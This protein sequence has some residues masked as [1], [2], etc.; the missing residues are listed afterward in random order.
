M[1]PRVI[2]ADDHA[3]VLDGLERLIEEDFEVAA[4]VTNGAALVDA[5]RADPPDAV[6]TDVT[7]PEVSGIQAVRQLNE[8]GIDTHFIV[9][10]MHDDPRLAREALSAGARGFLLKSA[11]GRELV[12]AIHEVLDGRTYLS[13]LI[14]EG[15]LDLLLTSDDESSAASR[16]SAARQ[17]ALTPRQREVLQL[18]AEGHSMKGIARE[19]EISRRTVESHKYEIMRKI[20]ASSTAELVLSAVRLGLVPVSGAAERMA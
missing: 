6:V 4:K 1:K 9:L 14:T 13:S 12:Q 17:D 16:W 10:T 5:V 19:L 11:A 20:G 2:L 7:M 18:V 8:E 3:I 15:T